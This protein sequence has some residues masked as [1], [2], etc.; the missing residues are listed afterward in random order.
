MW[1]PSEVPCCV[2][3]SFHL[4]FFFCSRWSMKRPAAARRYHFEKKPAA[5]DTS[6]SDDDPEDLLQLQEKGFKAPMCTQKIPPIQERNLPIERWFWAGPPG[7]F[8]FFF[9]SLFRILR[10]KVRKK[11]VLTGQRSANSRMCSRHF[12][13]SFKLLGRLATWNKGFQSLHFG[14]GLAGVDF[15]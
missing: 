3:P 1:T 11:L 5:R 9:S 14:G 13:L 12:L 4:L 7:T 10:L 8:I 15:N 6:S 2:D